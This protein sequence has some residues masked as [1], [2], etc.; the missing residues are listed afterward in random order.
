[1]KLNKKISKCAPDEKD[2]FNELPKTDIVDDIERQILLK[3]IALY[4]VE[5]CFQEIT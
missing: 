2:N 3:I 1:M 5:I 4:L